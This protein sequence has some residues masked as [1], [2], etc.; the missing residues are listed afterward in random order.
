MSDAYTSNFPSHRIF[1]T[2]NEYV[3]DNLHILIHADDA[4]LIATTREF[5]IRKLNSVLTYCKLNSI[6]LQASKCYFTVV[7][8]SPDDTVR[9]QINK[10]D[11]VEYKDHLEILGSHISR[12]L[13]KDLSLHFHDRD[14]R[15]SR[16]VLQVIQQE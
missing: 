16:K 3:L 7:N 11:S 8:A 6:V 15:S 13:E 5:M 12:C 10:Q 4:N 14:P 2:N 1:S 9:L